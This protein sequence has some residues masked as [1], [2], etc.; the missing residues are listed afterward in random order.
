MPI[1]TA[2]DVTVFTDISA[3]AGTIITSGLI[4]VVQN[5]I[6][7]ICN[8]PF[9]TDMYV[10]AGMTFSSTNGTIIASGGD[11]EIM[12]FVSGDEVY[13]YN[14]YRN[15]SY[16]VI[17]AASAL[18]LTVASGYSVVSEPSGRS[19]MISVVK[20]PDEIK[21][22]AAQMVKYDY[23]DRPKRSIGVNSETLGPYSV[24]Y[25]T[26]G[27]NPN[28]YGYPQEFIDALIAYKLVSIS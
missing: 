22:I 13:I 18:T 15:D 21:Y 12:G 9:V 20:W 28:P 3:S 27:F 24:S 10:T 19:I 8:N 4:P 14:S 6:R 23:D 7:T 1:C 25:G 5:R 16:K 26:A 17:S 2:T 11:F